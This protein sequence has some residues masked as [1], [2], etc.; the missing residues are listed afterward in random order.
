MQVGHRFRHAGVGAHLW[1]CGDRRVNFRENGPGMLLH[2]PRPRQAG[3]RIAQAGNPL[4]AQGQPKSQPFVVAGQR[5]A[6]HDQFTPQHVEHVQ[7][8]MH[9]QQGLFV[10]PQRRYVSNF[11]FSHDS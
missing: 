9:G 7:Q 5:E 3:H 6:D 11:D 2:P 1:M 8:R 4:V 10:R